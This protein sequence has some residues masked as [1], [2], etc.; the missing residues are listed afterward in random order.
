MVGIAGNAPTFDA[1]LFR[2][3]APLYSSF[4]DLHRLGIMDQFRPG[5]G[6]DTLTVEDVWFSLRLPSLTYGQFMYEYDGQLQVSLIVGTKYSEK[7]DLEMYF[8]IVK[9]WL[10]ALV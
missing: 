2:S 6:N 8:D 7:R 9:E 5:S 4:G 3:T 10:Y 1:G